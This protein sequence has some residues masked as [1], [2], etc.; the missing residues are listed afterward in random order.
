MLDSHR[1]AELKFSTLISHQAQFFLENT[2]GQFSLVRDFLQIMGRL[3]RI[4]QSHRL[5]ILATGYYLLQRK[6]SIWTS[7]LDH[8]S[9]S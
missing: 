3:D 2:R 1:G 4:P 7:S 9:L 8:I 5:L 6:L